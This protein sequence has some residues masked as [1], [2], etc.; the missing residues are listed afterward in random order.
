MLT[1]QALSA[2]DRRLIQAARALDADERET[3]IAFAEFLA[4]RREPDSMPI[5]EPTREP[6]PTEE[7]VVGAIKRLRRSFPMLDGA[8][9]LDETST[10]M[11]AHLLQGVAAGEVIDRLEVLFDGHYASYRT[12]A[13]NAIDPA[14]RSDTADAAGNED[15]ERQA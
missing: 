1:T 15:Q 8:D 7:S 3:L 4:A 14:D 13:L 5:A 2:I 10:L 6:R 11:S 12:R 9:L